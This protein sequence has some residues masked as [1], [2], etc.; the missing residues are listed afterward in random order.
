MKERKDKKPK[1]PPA[2]WEETCANCGKKF[3][4][5]QLC[6][7]TNVILKHKPVCSFECNVALGQGKK[8]G[9]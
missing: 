9:V 3:Q 5:S 1:P 8:K 2:Y 7:L 6:Y 4:Q